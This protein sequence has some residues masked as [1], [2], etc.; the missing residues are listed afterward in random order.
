M[1]SLITKLPHLKSEKHKTYKAKP[2]QK[3]NILE[4]TYQVSNRGRAKV[5][6]RRG[7][8]EIILK[9][10]PDKDGYCMAGLY[11]NGKRKMGKIHRLVLEAFVGPCPP[12]MEACHE[13]GIKSDN[14][15]PENLRWDTP[16]SNHAD[17]ARHGV[18]NRGERNGN[19][20]FTE[21][22]IREIRRLRAVRK[23]KLVRIAKKF[24][25]AFQTI[26]NICLH[27]SWAH[28]KERHADQA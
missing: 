8:P 26:S 6:P 3:H 22:D 23:W 12:G 15:W 2:P 18:T 7:R 17:R 21:K 11:M 19:A 5:L 1:E 25:T 24:N 4:D 28:I 13:N 9:P 20:I 16:Q 10:M 27:K 14:R